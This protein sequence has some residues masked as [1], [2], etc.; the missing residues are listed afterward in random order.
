VLGSVAHSPTSAAGREEARSH[1]VDQAAAVAVARDGKLLVAGVSGRQH[2]GD[3]TLARY[4]S[5]GRLDRSFGTGGKVVT[6]FG[7][8]GVAV[9]SS[10]A[11]RPDGKILVGGSASIPRERYSGAVVVRYTAAGNLDRTFG[12]NGKLLTRGSRVP[13][14]ANALALQADG[15]LVVAGTGG[16]GFALARYTQRGRLD[17][18]FGRGGTV[19]T[20][21]GGTSSIA[22]AFAAAIQPDGKIVVAGG[23]TPSDRVQIKFALARYTPDGTLD[24]RFGNRGRV[25]TKVGVFDTEAV[26]LVIQADGKLVVTGKAVAG[27]GVGFALVR[28]SADGKLDP[29]FGRGGIAYG[30]GTAHAL[31]IQR[32]G[33]LVTAGSAMGRYRKFWL[34]R[35]QSDGIVDESFGR[36]GKRSTDFG[37]G[38]I[39]SAVA[40]RPDGRIVAAGTVASRDFALAGY[41]TSGNLDRSFGIGGKVRTDF[42]SV[43]AG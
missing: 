5:G 38:A 21:F 18:S 11:I 20:T 2:Y 35:F 12:R 15:K 43:A 7:A 33:K 3:F 16:G 14:G 10:L 36:R 28:Y 29:S 6:I 25:V 1:S 27:R 37:A 8:R 17:R 23:A 4:T 40:I 19:V 42:S 24:R 26:D 22:Q 9:A 30:A 31:A 32:D 34:V 39:A 13:G 41:T